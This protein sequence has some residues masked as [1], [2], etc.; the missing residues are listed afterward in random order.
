MKKI[1][2]LLMAL[3]I[4]GSSFVMA[5]NSFDH[6]RHLNGLC[7]EAETKNYDAWK[8]GLK[9]DR[10][11]ILDR[12]MINYK[13]ADKVKTDDDKIAICGVLTITAFVKDSEGSK[14]RLVT[15]KYICYLF[16]ADVI[17]NVVIL[18]QED[19]IIIK[20]WDD[21]IEYENVDF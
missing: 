11:F 14:L 21:K 16:N 12:L 5:Q 8:K 1:S 19:P 7:K 4:F 10:N 13:I 9:E 17:E 2:I 20:K 6:E 18:G 3:L 15:V